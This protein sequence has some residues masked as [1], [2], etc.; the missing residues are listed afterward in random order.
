MSTTRTIGLAGWQ[1]S[2]TSLRAPLVGRPLKPARTGK[3]RPD[4]E[5]RSRVTGAGLHTEVG[6]RYGKAARMDLYRDRRE[7]ITL[8]RPGLR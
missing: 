6:A 5:S 1:P 8:P 2:G 4:T 7:F 3:A